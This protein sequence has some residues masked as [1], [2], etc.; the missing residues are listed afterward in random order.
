MR[1]L[2]ALALPLV[3]LTAACSDAATTAGTT[4]GTDTTIAAPGTTDGA[5]PSTTSPDKPKVELPATLPTELVVTDLVPGSGP[6]AKVG[7][8]VVVNY[9]GVRSADGTEFDNSYDR[10]KP[11][12]VLLGAGKVIPGWEQGLVGVQTGGRRQLDIPATLAYGDAG[13]GDVIKPGDALSFVVDVVAVL[14]GTLASD[15]PAITVSGAANV[16]VITNNDLIV[17]TGPSPS[18]GTQFAAQIMLFRADTGEL[19]NSTWGSPP[20]VFDYTTDSNTY[21]GIIAVAKGMKVGGRRQSQVPYQLMFDGQGQSQ[22]NLPAAI[23]L[24]IVMDMVAV[25]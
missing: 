7:D 9:I 11:F 1:R 24:V 12:E 5:A 8:E 17:G 20:I 3:V 14:P 22:I 10:G 4:A 13:A 19:L 25:Y 2:L 16:P 23:D 6:E 21:P 15:Q 18:N